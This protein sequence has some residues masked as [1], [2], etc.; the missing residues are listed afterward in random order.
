MDF[1]SRELRDEGV[2]ED[3]A[4]RCPTKER[5]LRAAKRGI[6]DDGL[7]QAIVGTS[8]AVYKSFDAQADSF[9]L[10]AFSLTLK[11]LEDAGAPAAMI[12]E[13]QSQMWAV[14]RSTKG[15]QGGSA[16]DSV[17]SAPSTPQLRSSKS[18]FD[19]EE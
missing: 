12:E 9:T 4:Q 1:V 2:E 18:I 16:S 8:A 6:E 15:R 17:C 7:L 10:A 14:L 5:K 11:I 19:S 3:A 13:V